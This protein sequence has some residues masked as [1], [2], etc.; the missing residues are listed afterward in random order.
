MGHSQSPTA[1]CIGLQFQLALWIANNFHYMDLK[2]ES[3]L[4]SK[5]PAF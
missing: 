1:I 5:K 4:L 2:I 3:S